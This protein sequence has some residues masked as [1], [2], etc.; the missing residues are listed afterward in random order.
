MPLVS[1]L[2]LVL[3]LDLQRNKMSLTINDLKEKLKQE[4][5]DF[6]LM[7]LNPESDELVEMLEELVIKQQDKLRLYY[8]DDPETLE[9]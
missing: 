8:D 5:Q 4:D 2:V 9:W 7:V 6:I 3:C 1:Y